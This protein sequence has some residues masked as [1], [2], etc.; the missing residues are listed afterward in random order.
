V[1]PF[2]EGGVIK[3]VRF[4]GAGRPK[5][6]NCSVCHD[7]T[8]NLQKAGDKKE[9]H[10]LHVTTKNARCF[11]CHRLIEHRKLKTHDPL[12][13]DCLS[14]H[15]DPHRFQRLLAAG[16]ERD[17]IQPL[18]DPMFKA[19]ASCLACHVERQKT[20][21][22]QVVMKAS[23]RTCV[24]CHTKD[25]E[26]MLELWK[27]ELAREIEKAEKLESEALEALTKHESE[28]TKEKLKEVNRM[29]EFG[30]ENLS[31]VRFGNGVHNAKYS[32]SLLDSAIDSFKNTIGYLEGK[33]MSE[34]IR[35][36][37]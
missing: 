16:T 6:E 7:Q 31:I 9:M 26:R 2:F 30:R 28:M 15:P 5:Y 17:V 10:R 13:G 21:K 20:H 19:R 34:G 27:R 1:E 35:R 23:A 22:G 3:T 36:E 18:P 4:I 33:D 24:Q 14:C 11:D 25:Y 12:P 8:K 32:I 29:L 37:E